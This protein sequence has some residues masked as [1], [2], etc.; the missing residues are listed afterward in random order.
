MVQKIYLNP[1]PLEVYHYSFGTGVIEIIS[2]NICRDFWQRNI[3]K[4]L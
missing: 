2:W 1:K 3:Q 4:E